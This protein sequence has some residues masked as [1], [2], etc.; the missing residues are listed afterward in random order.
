MGGHA[1]CHEQEDEMLDA[2]KKTLGLDEESKKRREKAR[3]KVMEEERR[4][5]AE[6]VREGA[7]LSKKYAK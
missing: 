7:E 5:R 4:E 3:E 2:I 6:R 1:F